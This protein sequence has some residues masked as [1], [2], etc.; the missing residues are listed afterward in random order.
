MGVESMLNIY[1][2]KVYRYKQE[3]SFP[4]FTIH[5]LKFALFSILRFKP[6]RLKKLFITPYHWEVSRMVI[7]VMSLY[8]KRPVCGG[9]N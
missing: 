8:N 3:K 9:N 5:Y 1:P 2:I 4:N 6:P 7:T